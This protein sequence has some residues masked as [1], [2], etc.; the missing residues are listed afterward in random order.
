[1]FALQYRPDEPMASQTTGVSM[2]YPTVCSGADKK[3][4]QSAASLAYVRGI[5]RWNP[6]TQA[7]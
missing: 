3:N 4:H 5:R 7:E 2:V 1:M 6:G